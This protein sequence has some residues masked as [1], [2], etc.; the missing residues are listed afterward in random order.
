MQISLQ[1]LYLRSVK[2]YLIYITALWLLI[3]CNVSRPT[4]QSETIYVSIAPLRS[5]V[6]AIVE[7]DFPVEV[8]VQPGASPE[9]FEPTPKQFIALN[10]AQ[11]IFG[12]GLI[13]FETT[14]LAKLSD[15]ARII[16]LSQG[17][18]PIAGS[19]S[20]HHGHH[21]GVDPHIWTSPRALKIMS[22]TIYETIHIQY[23]D[24]VRYTQNFNRLQDRL[25]SLDRRIDERISASGAKAFIL[26]H[27]ALTYYARDY[28]LRQ[29]SIEEDGKEPSA[30][31][32]ASL[33]RTAEAEGIRTVMVQ[34][35]YPTSSVEA[36][37]KDMEAQVVTFD[38]LAEDVIANLEHITDL[39]IRK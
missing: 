25:D 28:G 29:I 22:R 13:D 2:R 5:L 34:R 36:I 23:P 15:H 10:E 38:P 31:R 8:L 9:T 35:Q 26:Y 39:I 37:A 32:L 14:L 21:H 7:Q 4:Q 20:H 6:E 33:I 18:E 17:I 3:A 24:S 12:T 27:P 19:C 30:K 16:D 11:W 1:N